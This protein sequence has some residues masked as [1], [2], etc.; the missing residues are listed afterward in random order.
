MSSS[1]DVGEECFSTY[2]HV[3]R[4][5]ISSVPAHGG[6]DDDELVFGDEV[7]DAAFFARGLGT[8]VGLDVELQGGGEGEEEGEKELH[9]D[10]E[11]CVLAPM[12]WGGQWSV[13][14]GSGRTSSCRRPVSQSERPLP[15]EILA[16][17]E[18]AFFS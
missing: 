13:G 9:G 5:A 12:Q 3:E 2:M 17:S 10:G 7:A 18:V 16:E 8:G 14:G 4:L 11:H 6:R 15:C 1:W